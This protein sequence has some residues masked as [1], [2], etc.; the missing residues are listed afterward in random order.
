MRYPI[1]PD[2]AVTPRHGSFLSRAQAREPSGSVR[3]AGLPMIALD[4]ARIVNG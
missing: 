4:I 2:R 3:L 1:E